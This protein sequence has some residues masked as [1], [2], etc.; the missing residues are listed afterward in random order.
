MKTSTITIA[1]R[2]GCVFEGEL[3]DTFCFVPE[4]CIIAEGNSLR[5]AEGDYIR[6]RW[7]VRNVRSNDAA[8]GQHLFPNAERPLADLNGEPVR[9]FLRRISGL[10]L[11]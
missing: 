5:V 6:S 1:G 8:E 2:P 11:A 9:I 7:D 10:C 4:D 3:P